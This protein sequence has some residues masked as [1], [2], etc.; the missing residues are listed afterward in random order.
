ME[1]AT[2][3]LQALRTLRSRRPALLWGLML[4]LVLKAAVPW[5]AAVSAQQRGLALAE[6]C[7]VYGVRTIAFDA[8]STDTTPTDPH[9]T[10]VE[11]CP[12]MPLLAGAMAA[13]PTAALVELHA[14]AAARTPP[15]AL[16]PL[17]PD[18]SLAWLAGQTHAPPRL[19]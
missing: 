5:L 1:L 11:H 10:G 3:P 15:P 17:P 19:A 9:N 8:S 7:S 18:A 6:V 14:P 12:L 13:T 4:L 16:A 2:T